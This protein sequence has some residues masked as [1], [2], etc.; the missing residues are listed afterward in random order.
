MG[1]NAINAQGEKTVSSDD[2][3][4]SCPLLT[5]AHVARW[6][7]PAELPASVPRHVSQ[8]E[9][10]QQTNK[11]RVGFQPVEERHMKEL[12]PL[13]NATVHGLYA[14]KHI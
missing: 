3:S 6:G 4:S 12:V 10:N 1:D 11:Q 13:Y 5:R 14:A 9:I 7:S 8:R 2:T